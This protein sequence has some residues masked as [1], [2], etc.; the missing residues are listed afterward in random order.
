M[1]GSFEMKQELY[2]FQQWCI[3]EG[4]EALPELKVEPSGLNN[5]NL[6]VQGFDSLIRL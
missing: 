3:V 2:S 1:L 6:A 5:L 4:H